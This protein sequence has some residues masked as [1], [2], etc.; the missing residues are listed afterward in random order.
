MNGIDNIAGYTLTTGTA[1]FVITDSIAQY[2]PIIGN[3]VDGVERNYKAQFIDPSFNEQYETGRGTWNATAGT[4]SRDTI[5]TSSNNG[6]IVDFGAGPKV[7]FIVSDYESLTDMNNMVDSAEGAGSLKMTTAERTNIAANVALLAT[8]GEAFTADYGT[9]AGTIAEGDDARFGSVDIGD[10]TPAASI[11][12]TELFPADQGGS[13]VS[14]TA[15]QILADPYA[16]IKGYAFTRFKGYWGCTDIRPS[17]SSTTDDSLIDNAPLVLYRGGAAAGASNLI[18]TYLASC[19]GLTTGTD[20]TGYAVAVH[21]D[22]SYIFIPGTSDLDQRWALLI[23]VLP[24]SGVQDFTIQVGFISGFP[25]LAVQ[26]I[27]LELTG[28]SPNW[29]VCVKDVAGIERVDTG[30][31]AIAATPITLRVAYSGDAEESRFWIDGV[32]TDPIFD[33]TRAVDLFARLGMVCG[34]R[35][36]AGTTA[37]TLVFSNHKYDNGKVAVPHFS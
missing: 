19:V 13:G 22:T 26:G 29:F 10:L 15:D 35:K 11:A 21:L 9:T 36:T 24:T 32:A 28:A 5:K 34:I 4:I 16:Q 7:V 31:A 6:L 25:A 2:D 1:D 23:P 27:Y 18:G 14:I 12:G 17:Y 3:L 37:R 20:T 33:T 30:I 8:R